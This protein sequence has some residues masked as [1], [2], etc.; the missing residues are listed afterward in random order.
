MIEFLILAEDHRFFR[1]PGVDPWA[2]CRAG[3]KTY[4][5]HSRQGGSTIAM[6]LVRTLTG[7]RERSCERKALE[8][9][10]AWRLSRY[11]S[12]DRL[13]VLYLWC[14]YY[15]WRMSN[16]RDACTRLGLNP[17]STTA[18]DDALLVARLKYPEPRYHDH[19]STRRIRRRALHI[20]SLAGLL[21]EHSYSPFLAR[22]S[23][24]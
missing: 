17:A 15:G 14:A 24:L 23:R 5:C 3:W 10:L 9:A 7:R 11:L 21:P 13:P 4:F 19:R 2:L 8:I 1:H 22:A 12:R 18:L 6:Q 20:L 16:F